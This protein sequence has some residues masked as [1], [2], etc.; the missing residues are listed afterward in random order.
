[1]GPLL[2]L[3]LLGLTQ[4]DGAGG[5]GWFSAQKQADLDL[6]VEADDFLIVRRL[7]APGLEDR[8]SLTW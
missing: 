6:Q 8:T 7:L 5:A 1:M 2:E 3:R 4:G